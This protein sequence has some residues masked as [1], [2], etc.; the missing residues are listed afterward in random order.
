LADRRYRAAVIE[1]REGLADIATVWRSLLEKAPAGANWR[2]D[3]VRVRA[4]LSN[5]PDLTPLVIAVLEDDLLRCVAPFYLARER[6]PLKFR[7]VALGSLPIRTVFLFGDDIV[8]DQRADAG[9]WFDVIFREL[10]RRRLSFD[11]ISLQGLDVNGQLARFCAARMSV[12]GFRVVDASAVDRVH[13][14]VLP[15]TYSDYLASLG[16]RTRQNLRRTTRRLFEG[17]RA[18]VMKAITAADVPALLAGLDIVGPQ[19]WQAGALGI[20][21]RNTYAERQIFEALASQGWLRAYLLLYDDLPIA[22]ELGFQYGDTF[23]GHECGYDQRWSDRGP[24]SVLMHL[25]IEDLFAESRPEVLHFGFGDA[26]YKRS[27][28]SNDGYDARHVYLVS[29]AR[30]S[31]LLRLKQKLDAW[32]EP[33]VRRP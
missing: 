30:W 29:R 4:V 25:V 10:H 15:A 2:N 32:S 28:R 8:R 12:H 31:T 11:A 27:L 3:P 20:A 24:G 6:F 5:K 17:G 21:R 18:R 33:R 14:I 19:T 9:G 1:S 26:A 13:R 23:F 7:N 22:Y 16:A